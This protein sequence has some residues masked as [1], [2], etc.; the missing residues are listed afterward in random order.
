MR[1][2]QLRSYRIKEGELDEWVDEWRQQVLP[3]R[4]DHGFDVLG[5]WIVRAESRFVWIIG[6]DEFEEADAR[7][8]ASPERI[9][10][11]PDPARHLAEA[12]TWLMEPLD[13]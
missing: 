12:Q 10:L 8:Y 5:P 1:A 3:L 9:A 6:H 2:Y 4:R 11:D 13:G 7:Y